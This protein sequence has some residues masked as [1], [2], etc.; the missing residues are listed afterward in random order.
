M[1]I[2]TGNEQFLGE[3]ILDYAKIIT[4][5]IKHFN[6]TFKGK[7]REEKREKRRERG[8]REIAREKGREKIEKGRR[9]RDRESEKGGR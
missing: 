6:L 4:I 3:N 9:S 2:V 5:I 1:E 7:E 8:G